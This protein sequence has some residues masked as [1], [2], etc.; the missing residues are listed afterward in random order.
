[1]PFLCTGFVST[2]ILLTGG[3]PRCILR[4]EPIDPNSYDEERR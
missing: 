1:L 3:N 2:C 4:D